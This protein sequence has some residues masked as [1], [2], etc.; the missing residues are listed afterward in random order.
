MNAGVHRELEGA[1]YSFWCAYNAGLKE[2][3]ASIHSVA[4][5]QGFAIGDH[6]IRFF[7]RDVF[8]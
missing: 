5:T 1:V 8:S 2:A 4:L 7:L 6:G 3:F